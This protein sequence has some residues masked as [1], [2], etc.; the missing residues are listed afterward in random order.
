MVI[1][2]STSVALSLKSGQL[3]ASGFAE[4]ELQGFFSVV[5]A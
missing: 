5:V 4:R 1:G 3:R 2:C